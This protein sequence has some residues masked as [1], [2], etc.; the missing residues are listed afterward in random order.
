MGDLIGTVE[1]S[2]TNFSDSLTQVSDEIDSALPR[3][4]WQGQTNEF[5]GMESPRAEWQGQTNEFGGMESPKDTL[6]RSKISFG[7]LTSIGP[8]GMPV[9]ASSKKDDKTLPKVTN[10]DD[11][12]ENAKFN[13]QAE[14]SKKAAEAKTKVEEDKKGKSGDG[15]ETK[16]LDDVVKAL[17][18]LNTGM[19]KLLSVNSTNTGLMRDQIKA[20]KT[21]G[22]KNLYEAHL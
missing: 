9:I 5:G 16:T 11:A 14:E 12:R 10:P 20:T 7:T 17:E 3:A 21:S 2:S 22:S 19:E 4:E 6:D 15:A 18:K 8:N 1:N 13:R